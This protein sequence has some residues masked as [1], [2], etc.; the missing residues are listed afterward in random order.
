VNGEMVGYSQGSKTPAEFNISEY[1]K[2]GEN[3]V[4]V[5]VY[6]WTDASYIEDQ[7]AW[8]L[9]GI[10]RDVYLFATPK[11]HI[12]DFF[13]KAELDPNFSNGI[14]DLEVE[15][16]NYGEQSVTKTI[17]VQ[18]LDDDTQ[19][20]FK[21]KLNVEDLNKSEKLTLKIE[22]I[23]KSVHKWSA[24]TPYLYTL[25]IALYD[26]ANIEEVLT[27][28]IG[29]RKVE[30]KKGQLLVNGRALLIKGVNRHEHH[31]VTGRYVD[32][33]TMIKDIVLMKQ[34]NINAVRTSHYP[35][36]PRWYELCDEYGLYVWDETNIESHFFWSKFSIDPDWK[37]AFVDRM[38]RMV[39]RDKNHP[40]VIVWSLGNE[41]GYGPNHEAMGEWVR[42]RDPTRLIHYEGTEPGYIPEPGHF[43]IIAN[44]YPSVD[45]MIN[46]SYMDTTRPVILCEY[47]HAMGNSVGNLYKYWDAIEQYP[48]L[49]GGFIWDW[50]DQGLLK[51]DE[52]GIEYYAYGGDFGEEL[53][54]SNFCA[55]GLIFANRT[56]QPELFEVKKIY[57]FIK[58][59]VVNKNEGIYKVFNKYE[60]INLDRFYIDWSLLKNGDELKSGKIINLEVPP[61]G[62][63]SFTIPY[64]Y[65]SFNSTSEYII[66]ISYRLKNE[67][68]WAD[69]DFEIAWEQFRLKDPSII[70][71]DSEDNNNK[72]TLGEDDKSISII[73]ADFE[74]NFS[75][76]SGT[77]SSYLF[78]GVNLIERGPLPNVWR[79][80]TDNDN[81][82]GKGS[83]G[84]IWRRDGLDKIKFVSIDINAEQKDDILIRV[85]A[86][87]TLKA[88]KGGY[89]WNAIYSV[90]RNGK[91]LID[92]S[93]TPYG[94][95][96]ILPKIGLQFHIP[97]SF[98]NI[99]WYGKGPY[100]A[101][102]DRNHGAKEGK[103]SV[104]VSELFVPYIYP[105]EAGNLADVRFAAITDKNKIGLFVKGFPATEVSLHEYSLE[106]I[107]SARHTNELIKAEYLTLN[108][109][110]LQMGLG[111]DDSWNPRTHEEFWVKPKS[112]NY[113]LMIAPFNDESTL[114]ELNRIPNKLPIPK[115]NANDTQFENF[116]TIEIISPVK[117]TTIYYTLDGTDPNSQSPIYNRPFK[118]LH[119]TAINAIVKKD[120]FQSSEV[121]SAVFRKKDKVFESKVFT[122]NDDA[123]KLKI[124]VSSHELLYLIVKD[125]DDGTKE[126]HADWADAKF[127]TNNDEIIYLSDLVPVDWRQ[128]WNKLGK[129]KS[130]A[131]NTLNINGQE[132][133]KGLGTHSFG[134]ILFKIPT[135][136][137]YFESFIGLDK[138]SRSVGSVSFEIVLL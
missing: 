13:A 19:I 14:L 45:L 23:I 130:V 106:N 75:K 9:S 68:K 100:E 69:R 56:P 6:R 51:K 31:P 10:Y 30:L 92:N 89:E 57:Q 49:Q 123:Q 87:G 88:A 20:I 17:D 113:S 81:G 65:K 43:D 104:S 40:S 128:G 18:I 135:N 73:G 46:L 102:A 118:I 36:A 78:E 119:S 120:G 114:T 3:S 98:E 62:N 90:F 84:S 107:T 4:S 50:V 34:N 101:Y 76:E 8:R 42:K 94:Y 126:D 110:L 60:F 58:T 83:F 32:E 105:Q 80:P 137:K 124:D 41:S 5:K 74:I 112:Y 11:V 44:M 53:H 12:R 116:N 125:G 24:E 54:D 21:R 108:L 22:G 2:E 97:N 132:Y 86:S 15:V 111:G 67:T 26:N 109:D 136:A 133:K 38:Q 39:E 93:F 131:G 95:L 82:G 52:N 99:D 37:H 129:D 1:L 59:Q 115:I 85:E 77:I 25:V 28:K 47:A 27:H 55:N 134:E 72:L 122:V 79:A 103:Y 63:Q 121:A 48:R 117:G 61:D 16:I 7:D 127:I 91:I 35:N 138:E 29:F 70:L 71:V 64:D 33:E 66:T 96:P